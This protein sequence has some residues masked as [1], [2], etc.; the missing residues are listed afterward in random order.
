MLSWGTRTLPQTSHAWLPTRPI[1]MRSCPIW[2]FVIKG[3]NHQ[4]QCHTMDKRRTD[5]GRGALM[6]LHQ[7]LRSGLI[8]QNI[9]PALRPLL[10]DVEYCQVDGKTDNVAQVDEFIRILLTK[11]FRHL[12]MFCAVLA[13]NQY[14]HWAKTLRQEVREDVREEVDISS[15]GMR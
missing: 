4:C 2:K 14:E 13:S 6:K 5:K 7:S 10:T 9:L 8:L 1:G 11:E 15:E 3:D 12:E